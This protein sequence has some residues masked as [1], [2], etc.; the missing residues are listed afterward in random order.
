MPKRKKQHTLFDNPEEE[1]EEKTSKPVFS[2]GEFLDYVN[3]IFKREEY[4]VLGEISEF[5]SHP[6]GVYVTLK[7]KEGEGVLN[8]YI[9]PFVYRTAGISLEAGLLVKVHGYPS[10]HKPKGKFSFVVKEFELFGEG[11]LRRA[12]ELLKK[13]LEEEG[14]FRRKRELP[15]CIQE[16]GIITSKTGAVIDDF[17]K[18]LKPLGMKLHLFDV[19]VEGSSAPRNIIKGIRWFNTRMPECDV[20]VLIRGGGSLEDLQPFNNEL[21]AREIFASSIP[22][23]AGIGHDRDVPIASLV[24]DV[25]TSTPSFAAMAVNASWDKLML[26]LPNLERELF[27][28]FER[29][30]DESRS[31]VVAHTDRLLEKISR[32]I[33]RYKIIEDVIVNAFSLRVQEVNE[34]L[35][36]TA[37]YLTAVD[38]ERNLRLGYSIIFNEK[39]NVVRDTADTGEGRPIAVRLHKGSLKARVEQIEQNG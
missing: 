28:S 5:N 7:D 38:P 1:R 35:K 34:F 8:C 30:L 3:E 6:T 10:I 21:V 23:I 39:G 37:Q 9:N 17:R 36:R 4:T 13:K 11:S 19:R 33:T 16:V 29:A 22:V 24:A 25:M 14:L 12:Y 32:L 26:G 20:I 27:D 15:E 31:R 18:N 2:V